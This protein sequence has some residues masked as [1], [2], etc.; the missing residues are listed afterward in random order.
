MVTRTLL[1]L[2][3]SLLTGQAKQADAAKLWRLVLQA[4]C[5]ASF[6]HSGYPHGRWGEHPIND[7]RSLCWGVHPSIYGMVD[8]DPTIDG[9]HIIENQN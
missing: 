6:T 8:V 9:F 2:R 7:Q 3:S 4:F 1:E 5:A